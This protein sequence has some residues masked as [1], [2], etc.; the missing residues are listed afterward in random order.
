MLLIVFRV[1]I[2]EYDSPR[3][4]TRVLEEDPSFDQNVSKAASTQKVQGSSLCH[5]PT[6]PR[7]KSWS[8]T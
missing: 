6:P 8:V 4:N 2:S 5:G 7:T 3:I 1:K